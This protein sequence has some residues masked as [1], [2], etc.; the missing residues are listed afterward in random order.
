MLLPYGNEVNTD[1]L[2][3]HFSR[4]MFTLQVSCLTLRFGEYSQTDSVI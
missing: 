4:T 2:S 3:R 1:A